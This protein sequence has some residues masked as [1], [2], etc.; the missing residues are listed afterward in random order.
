[1][2]NIGDGW[3]SGMHRKR[4][5]L[6]LVFAL[7][8]GFLPP[9]QIGAQEEVQEAGEV[10]TGTD[11]G[12]QG[13]QII[14][15]VGSSRTWDCVY[16]GH[17]W[18]S[19]TNDDGIA[20]REDAKEPILWRVL[21]VDGDDAFLL[22]ERNLEYRKYHEKTWSIPVTWETSTMRSW[23][24][25]YD[26]AANQCALDYTDDNFLDDAFS[27]SEQA[28]IRN[29]DVENQDNEI[30]QTEGGND[31]KDKIYLLSFDEATTAAYGFPTSHY[32]TDMRRAKDT[33]YLWEI[34]RKETNGGNDKSAT[35]EDEWW[36][37]S[38]GDGIE[39]AE[40]DKDQYPEG[41]VPSDR[42]M[43]VRSGLSPNKTSVN[44]HI[45]QDGD[46]VHVKHCVRPVLHLDLSERSLWTYA[47]TVS[48]P[49]E[50]HLL[51]APTPGET[52]VSSEQPTQT[53]DLTPP[54]SGINDTPVPPMTGSDGTTTWDCVYF[55]RYWQN[56]T[57]R[58]GTAD[59]KDAKEKIKWRVLSVDGD[60]V[61]LLADK[62]IAYQPYNETWVDVTWANCTMRSW[63][64]GY[65][66]DANLYGKNYTHNNFL[67]YAFSDSERLAIRDTELVN[68]D[69]EK[70]GTEGGGDTTDQVY[71]LSGDDAVNPAYGFSDDSSEWDKARPA[72]TT[73]YARTRGVLA[74][75]RLRSP[76]DKNTS[77]YYVSSLGY[78]SFDAVDNVKV[79]VR[80]ALRLNTAFRTYWSNA[81]KVTS[82]GKVIPHVTPT[83]VATP[84]AEPSATPTAP[85]TAESS[86]TPTTAP[87]TGS[88]ATQ[89]PTEP[90]ATTELPAESG[91]PTPSATLTA[92]PTAPPTAE[93][94]V[95]PT[96]VP[97]AA[98]PTGSSV[99]QKP[100]QDP[101]AT[102]AVTKTTK[103]TQT[104]QLL[105]PGKVTGLKLK[106]KKRAIQVSWKKCPGAKGYEIWYS[107]S[108]KWKKK[109]IKVTKAAKKR[110]GK[111][112]SKTVYYVRIRAYMVQNGKKCYGKW[113]KTA[114]KRCR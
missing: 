110:I 64:N 36:L 59:R 95:T 76:G 20:N 35:K 17:Y 90:P 25:G 4:L 13:P 53:P 12:V 5:A 23:L 62:I 29:T 22:A 66:A 99:T 32:S 40:S 100:T 96:A 38:P 7:L 31:T 50:E 106:A 41:I 80:P 18:Q 3:I 19:D 88:S 42:A 92:T 46:A 103:I 52:L 73:E 43:L 48:V 75:W 16:F 1:M 81:G 24:N 112:K 111:L 10:T 39:I 21:S 94:S 45:N 67:N 63:L 85:P 55:G 54:F 109:K 47:G 33:D 89:K 2:R 91:K 101:P 57:N 49:I 27:P 68:E 44:G 28:A 93:P 107:P 72:E 34:C 98:P 14:P 108:K 87:P 77:T 65:D 71:L 97:A 70:Y 113:S 56:D 9:R 74:S 8:A 105:P 69:N 84:T 61:L 104:K 82:D 86:A 102:P 114:K 6:L 15:G 37:R 60:D 83:P 11:Y 51:P 79:G 78:V 58:D 30:Y 26:G